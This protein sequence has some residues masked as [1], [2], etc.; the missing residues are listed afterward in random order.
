M[1]ADTV[2]VHEA[3]ALQRAFDACGGEGA[4]SHW[5]SSVT[6]TTTN[7][8]NVKSGAETR[9]LVGSLA[10]RGAHALNA[11]MRLLTIASVPTTWT[12]LRGLRTGTLASVWSAKRTN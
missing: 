8:A 7:R 3:A 12:V 9:P 4:G 6:L 2:A 1:H 5:C 11:W 10:L